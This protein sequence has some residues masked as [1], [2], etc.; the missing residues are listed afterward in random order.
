MTKRMQSIGNVHVDVLQ[1]TRR[2]IPEL[3][4][5]AIVRDV[6]MYVEKEPWLYAQTWV[7]QSWLRRHRY[8]LTLDDRP[9]GRLLFSATTHRSDFDFQALARLPA[10]CDAVATII[11]EPSDTLW[12]RRS[13]FQEHDGRIQLVE[14]FLPAMLNHLTQIKE[15]T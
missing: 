9:I 12:A 3:A 4:A 13:H 7:E 15:Q 6:V 1:Q 2:F 8:W 14:V 5:Y 10:L 11:A